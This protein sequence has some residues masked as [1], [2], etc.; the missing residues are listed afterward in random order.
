MGTG[1]QEAFIGYNPTNGTAVAVTLN[2]DNPGPQAFM[3]I[4]AL[5]ASPELNTLTSPSPLP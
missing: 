3:A 2:V 4:E 1:A 5:T